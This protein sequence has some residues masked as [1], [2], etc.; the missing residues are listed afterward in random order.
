MMD[1]ISVT[2]DR[3]VETYERALR[4]FGTTRSG[5]GLAAWVVSLRQERG[6]SAVCVRPG[7]VVL[8]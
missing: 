7:A 2:G 5:T 1:G 6:L 8:D 4:A 3:T